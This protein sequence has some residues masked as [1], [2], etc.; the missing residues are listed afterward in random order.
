MQGTAAS[1][2][3]DAQWAILHGA[4]IRWSGASVQ[5]PFRRMQNCLRPSR[6][7]TGARCDYRPITP[8]FCL[9]REMGLSDS[10][11]VFVSDALARPDDAVSGERT[12]LPT[13]AWAD[14]GWHRLSQTLLGLQI[15]LLG[16][17]LALYRVTEIDVRWSTA[18]GFLIVVGELAALWIILTRLVGQRVL[19][20]RFAEALA[21]AILFFTLIQIT[22]PMQYG[23]LALGRPFIDSWLDHAD[24]WIGVDV[25][26]V[27]AWTAQY[28][29]LVST[30]TL[31]YE[32][33]AAQLLVPLVV[34]PIAR[35]RNALWEYLWHLHISLIVALVC[36]ALWP[37]FYVFTYQHFEP[38]VTP[39]LT[40][41]LMTQLWDIRAG[42]LQ[43]VTLHHLE[44]LISF[45]SFHTAAA[46]AVT[47]ALRRQPI[48]IWMPV[49]LV[50]V[51]L[52]SATV[53]LG[54]HYVTDLIGTAV[55]LGASL[56]LYRYFFTIQPR[57]S[58][59]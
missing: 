58:V 10:S 48:W 55:L 26:Q 6:T 44:G 46:L 27:T 40:E 35:D 23:A 25:A 30:L 13:T 36:L 8:V 22:A 4:T 34:L 32:T 29:W 24:H 15:L 37:T 53:L 28:P 21:A 57:R 19:L 9:Q 3:T 54:L 33:L 14:L 38:L 20:R 18:R 12:W 56:A 16:T 47:W 41:R 1:N 5:I 42:R 59:S 50:N 2:P 52:V 51:G 49:A 17:S 7:N 39:E 31:A 11:P 43:T 45:P